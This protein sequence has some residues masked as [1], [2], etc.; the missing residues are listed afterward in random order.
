MPALF[1]PLGKLPVDFLPVKD[2]IGMPPAQVALVLGVN[3][4]VADAPE[5]EILPADFDRE[6]A[7][8]PPGRDEGTGLLTF[9]AHTRFPIAGK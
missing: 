5:V 1:A 2:D 4:V 8:P 3:H 7:K 6:I 9:R